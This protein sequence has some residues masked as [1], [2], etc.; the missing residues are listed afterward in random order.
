MQIPKLTISK[1]KMR[2]AD[3][4]ETALIQLQHLEACQIKIIKFI[5]KEKTSQQMITDIR[6]CPAFSKNF[7]RFLCE[8]IK[9]N[10]AKFI[11]SAKK[12]IAYRQ[13]QLAYAKKNIGKPFVGQ[14][15]YTDGGFQGVLDAYYKVVKQTKCYVWLKK[16]DTHEPETIIRKIIKDQDSYHV[17]I[18]KHINAYPDDG[19]IYDKEK[20]YTM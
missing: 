4:L 15:L 20:I 14:I 1:E 12:G 16:L 2:S 10:Q 7:A 3:D 8:A 18:E 5:L 9:Q 13:H 11:Q 19:D 6:F 17:A